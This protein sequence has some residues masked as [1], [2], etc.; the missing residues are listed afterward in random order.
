M[1]DH[2][3]EVLVKQASNKDAEDELTRL[4]LASGMTVEE[5]SKV[6]SG[7][8]PVKEAF[9]G[10][11]ADDW[12]GK[13]EGSPLYDQAVA[14][15]RE[16][17]EVEAARI[18]ERQQEERPRFYE[19]EDM[20]R[21]KKR[22]LDLELRTGSLDEQSV[23]AEAPE[24]EEEE[25]EHGPG[26]ADEVVVS[27]TDDKVASAM[28]GAWDS[29]K[30]TA[31]KA[32][33]KA[34]DA[35]NKVKPHVEAAGSKAKEHKGKL[36]AGGLAGGLAAKGAY[37]EHSR[38]MGK[39]AE[40][41]FDLSGRAMAHA[42]HKTAA[43]PKGMLADLAA[44]VPRKMGGGGVSTK[45]LADSLAAGAQRSVSPAARTNA[46][47]G[48][49][50]AKGPAGKKWDDLVQKTKNLSSPEKSINPGTMSVADLMSAA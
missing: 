40:A 49:A 20:I 34:K 38:T 45:G 18:A 14:L 28:K 48:A 27:P 6:A 10:S 3:T 39:N 33:G 24:P 35:Y 22:Q 44:T 42:L 23:E 15:E 1:L 21:L 8:S 11:D 16:L 13:Y 2:F 4:F 50:K 32:K 46:L 37:D 7:E 36:I 30:G 47:D 9:C 41:Y 5:L 19:Q 43:L 29:V 31:G 12:L 17:L 25:E 26:N